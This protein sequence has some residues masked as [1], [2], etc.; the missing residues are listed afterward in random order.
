MAIIRLKP[1]YM[2][3]LISNY[4]WLLWYILFLPPSDY[5]NEANL[6]T[7]TKVQGTE[8]LTCFVETVSAGSPTYLGCITSTCH[9]TITFR[10]V[11]LWSICISTKTCRSILNSSINV[12][13]EYWKLLW[14]VQKYGKMSAHLNFA[15]WNG[16][17]GPGAYGPFKW[18]DFVSDGRAIS[19]FKRGEKVL[20][21][22]G[23]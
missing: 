3:P 4:G 23:P 14:L 12:S 8:T 11:A 22:C 19:H 16:V 6:H 18:L 10:S 13:L 1:C 9:V 5:A 20:Y 7:R 17:F 21:F 15:I 2:I